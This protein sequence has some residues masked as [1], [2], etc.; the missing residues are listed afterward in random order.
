VARGPRCIAREQGYDIVTAEGAFHEA[1]LATTA[2]DVFDALLRDD[3]KHTEQ[4]TQAR[5]DL[6]QRVVFLTGINYEA[7]QPESIPE[8]Q[9]STQF[10]SFQRVLRTGLSRA[11]IESR[12]AKDAGNLGIHVHNSMT[13]S[14]FVPVRLLSN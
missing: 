10:Q 1:L 14:L 3:P 2:H 9:A 4:T 13:I 12:R 6:A 11:Q 8:L 7:L 5:Q